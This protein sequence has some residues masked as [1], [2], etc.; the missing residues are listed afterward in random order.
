M[1]ALIYALTVVGLAWLAAA[2]ALG[3]IL[4]RILHRRDQQRPRNGDDQ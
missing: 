1:T 4:G 3:L 2:V